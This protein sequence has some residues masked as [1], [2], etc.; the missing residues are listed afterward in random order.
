[1][2]KKRYLG[3]LSLKKKRQRVDLVAVCSYLMQ[4]LAYTYSYMWKYL[5]ICTFS[6][7]PNPEET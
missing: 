2:Q 7:P 6:E 5:Q 3:L 1:M 4:K